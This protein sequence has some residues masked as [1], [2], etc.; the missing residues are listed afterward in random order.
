MVV[1]TALCFL[2]L[3]KWRVEWTGEVP[4]AHVEQRYCP[5]CGEEKIRYDIHDPDAWNAWVDRVT[6]NRISAMENAT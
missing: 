3:H 6:D 1:T 2:G 4:G 5:R